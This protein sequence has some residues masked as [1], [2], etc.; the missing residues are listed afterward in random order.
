MAKQPGGF[1]GQEMPE[2]A[3]I[4][5]NGKVSVD[6]F[7]EKLGKLNE[8]SGLSSLFNFRQAMLDLHCV[9][10]EVMK[11]GGF[12]QVT[13]KGKWDDVVLASIS[14]SRSCVSMSAAQLRSVYEMLILQYEL[15]YCGTMSSP[16]TKWPAKSSPG[17]FG[18]GASPSCSTGKRKHCDSSSPFSSVRLGDQDGW[19]EEKDRCRRKEHKDISAGKE[20]VNKNSTVIISE[21]SNA[22]ELTTDSPK[23]P[24]KPRTG[25]HIFLRLETQRLR[26]VLGEGSNSQNLREMA[27]SA[28]R[29]L[30]E[31]HKLPYIEASKMD[32]E[33]YAKEMTAYKQKG[34]SLFS[35]TTPNM[36]SFS[37]PK[38]PADD[39][40]HVSFEDDPKDLHSPDESMVGLAIKAMKNAGSSDSFFQID[41]DNGP[42]G[43]RF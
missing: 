34:M 12:Y 40:Y 35:T 15:M 42:P 11:R 3:V 17:Y 8:S 33:R 41:W 2:S 14:N 26:N 23:A 13:K 20:A 31:K 32:R 27:V 19:T 5:T 24:Q 16:A 28:W 29:S 38:E 30:P 7:Y 22:K 25:Y 43:I 10:M 6:L 18:S 4:S 9:Y 21:N 36:L 39:V 37:T 1:S